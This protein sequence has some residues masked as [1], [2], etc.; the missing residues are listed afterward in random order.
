VR[1]RS[2]KSVG[3]VAPPFL[4]DMASRAAW[5]ADIGRHAPVVQN[6]LVSNVPGPRTPLYI[7]GCQVSGLYAASVLVANQGLNI[8]VLSYTDRIDFGVTADADLVDDPWE[9]SDGIPD[10]LAELMDASG[11]GKPTQVYDPF[12]R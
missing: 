10:A 4:V 12:D 9:I 3:E 2:I 11:L 7:C 6:V 5:A 1:A 8:T